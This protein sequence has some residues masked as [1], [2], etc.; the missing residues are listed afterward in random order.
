MG[1]YAKSE[2]AVTLEEQVKCLEDEELLDFWM[3]TQELA[4]HVEN[5]GQSDSELNPEYERVIL[6]E[7]QFRNCRRYAL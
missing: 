2:D 3:E 7:L 1:Y 4:R 6:R 5:F